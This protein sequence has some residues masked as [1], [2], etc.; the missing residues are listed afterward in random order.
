M[1]RLVICCDG[2]WQSL[3]NG[4]PTNVQRIAQFV[5]PTASSE[6]TQIVY[7]DAGVGTSGLFDKF[8]GGALGSGLDHEIRE[9]YRFLALNYEINDEIYLFGFSR[10]AYTV[11][12]L[13]GLIYACGI[14]MRSKVRSIPRAMELYR[15]REIHPDDDE[16]VNFR[17]SNTVHPSQERPKIN[18]LGCWDTV[19]ALGVPDV[20]PLVDISALTGGKF[21]F[22]DTTLGNH[23]V[24]ARH[25]A[26]IDETRRPFDVT[27]MEQPD[28]PIEG[29]SLKQV[30]FPGSHGC[31]GGGDRNVREL[32]DGPLIWMISE[33]RGAGL[34]FND[35]EI[36]DYTKPDPLLP[37][38]RSAAFLQDVMGQTIDRDGPES[39][40]D[41][42]ED[43]KERCSSTSLQSGLYR[44]VPLQKFKSE[45]YG[46]SQ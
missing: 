32:S 42:S 11:R 27:T 25:A 37:F 14:V 44:P 34:E 40:K 35:K 7:Y 20:V 10:G 43:A 45:L 9:A 30:W 21:E 1:K 29:H 6:I 23:I 12:S 13:A 5:L 15:D 16:A 3:D 17:K 24:C 39:F 18:F 8:S 36:P 2:T 28:A 22:H 31:I 4:W 46:P 33:A 26:A 41:I 19:G 38:P